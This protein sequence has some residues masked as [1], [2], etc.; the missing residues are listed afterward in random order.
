MEER[1]HIVGKVC[2]LT[3]GVYCEQRRGD[4]RFNTLHRCMNQFRACRDGM[5]DVIPLGWSQAA[6]C[7]SYRWC[8]PPTRGKAVILAFGSGRLEAGRMS[9]QSRAPRKPCNSHRY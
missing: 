4:E 8:R 5:G 7:H 3:L 2:L 9:G 6:E 1:T